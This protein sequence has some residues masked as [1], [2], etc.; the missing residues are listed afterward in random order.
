MSDLHTL[1]YPKT[2]VVVGA[3]S[4]RH[5]IGHIISKNILDSGFK[6]RMYLV[7]SKGGETLGHTLYQSVRILPTMPELAILSIPAVGVP[8]SLKELGILGVKYVVI[9]A[10]GFKEVG[11][12]G[13]ALE[14]NIIEIAHKYGIR[15]VGP[16][17]LGIMNLDTEYLFNGSF[18]FTPQKTGNISIVSQSGAMISILIDTL[19]QNG[20]G[21]Q[22]VISMG[23][24]ADLYENDFV[25]YLLSDSKTGVIGLYIES[26]T[27]GIELCEIIR[28]SITPI[29]ILK[30]G[31]S[32]RAQQASMSHTGA[33]GADDVVARAH[34]HASGAYIVDNIEQFGILLSFLSSNHD[35]VGRLTENDVIAPI[36]ITNAGGV[37][38][39]TID[40]MSKR[41][42]LP[43][44]IDTTLVERLAQT[45]PGQ[46]SVHNPIDI[47]G[48][49]TS[50]RYGSVLEL[51][52]S[53]S[54]APIIAIITPQVNTEV[55]LTA[56]IILN[57]IT[58]YPN[59]LIFPV[60]M[61]EYH[62]NEGKTFLE[63][64]GIRVFSFPEQAVDVLYQ[65][66]QRQIQFKLYQCANN[67]QI[68]SPTQLEYDGS[69]VSL[70]EYA[71]KYG[72][73]TPKFSY[74]TPQI[75]LESNITTISLPAIIKVVDQNILHRTDQKM[76]QKVS[77][78]NEINSF[79]ENFPNSEIVLCQLVE[80]GIEIFVGIKRDTQFG[81][82][83]LLGS[84]GIYSEIWKDIV[85]ISMPVSHDIILAEFKKTR[86]YKVVAGFR[87]VEWDLDSIIETAMKLVTLM[88]NMPKN[89]KSI[90]VNP[91][92]VHAHG[93][94]AVDIKTS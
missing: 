47:L 46:A 44:S 14:Q 87:N 92:I 78:A 90:E 17:C 33:L 15:L 73:S 19:S 34:L 12:A 26:F 18:D 16:N 50:D 68:V 72:I 8:D 13:K 20:C 2:I 75:D 61:G 81:M 93:S 80:S 62:I 85:C 22:K 27:L 30:A 10:A 53:N 70:Q 79:C 59:N 94:T 83:L 51:C 66:Q 65:I 31:A 54:L 4:D 38:V 45:L 89:I 41:D 5:K 29:V 77:D 7:N 91:L 6:G 56:Q 55:K 82:S 11:D 64:A 43:L 39:V 3:S 84:G 63:Q 9:I 71:N 24:K 69:F 37:G 42:I 58:K 21:L 67:N 49:A 23:N 32:H 52:V 86:I 40:S 35:R 57:I 88:N 48:D 28:S 25:S 76:V 1:F 36:V 74:I 60:F